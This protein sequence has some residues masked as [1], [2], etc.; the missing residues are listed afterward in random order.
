ML[1]DENYKTTF[2]RKNMKTFNRFIVVT[3]IVMLSISILPVTIANAKEQKKVV[4]NPKISLKLAKTEKNITLSVAK[5]KNA[6]GY[7]VYVKF[8]PE[9]NDLYVNE[10]NTVYYSYYDEPTDSDFVQ[11]NNINQN[12]SKKR[13]LKLKIKTFT[14]NSNMVTF[15]AGTYSIRVRAY[16]KNQYGNYDYSDYVTKEVKVKKRAMILAIRNPMIFQM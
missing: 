1:Y 2:W 14:G 10:N 5:N 7:E 8:V 11:I 4:A 3:L 6:D 16:C 9:V 15:P 12:G 13:K